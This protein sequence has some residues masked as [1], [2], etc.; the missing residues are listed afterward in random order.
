MADK[1][2]V[3]VSL[4][5]RPEIASLDTPPLADGQMPPPFPP[6]VIETG[7]GVASYKGTTHRFSQTFDP[8]ATTAERIAFLRDGVTGDRAT[9]ESSSSSS[10][11]PVVGT[12]GG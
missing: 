12:T 8:S 5:L 6:S 9:G 4:R 7:S 2:S 10:P 1:V 3:A 11:D